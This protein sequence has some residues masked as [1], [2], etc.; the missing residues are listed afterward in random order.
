MHPF[1]RTIV[2]DG[3]EKSAS[4]RPGPIMRYSPGSS[5]IGFA[6]ETVSPFKRMT[7]V[8]RLFSARSCRFRADYLLEI[9][10]PP[11]EELV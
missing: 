11:V 4:S 10:Q 7:R 8:Q 5:G 9:A 2:F 3:P 6:N 1:M